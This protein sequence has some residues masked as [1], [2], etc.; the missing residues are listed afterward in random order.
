MDTLTTI[1]QAAVRQSTLSRDPQ[2]PVNNILPEIRQLLGVKKSQEP[3][4]T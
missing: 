2:I 3:H 4:A 1:L